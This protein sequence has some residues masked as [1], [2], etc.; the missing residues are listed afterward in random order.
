M[1]VCLM[2]FRCQVLCTIH[3]SKLL[4]F[5]RYLFQYPL[6]LSIELVHWF[7]K[8]QVV[9]NMSQVG[10][11]RIQIV[12]DRLCFNMKVSRNTIDHEKARYLAARMFRTMLLIELT[13]V[14]TSLFIDILCFGLPLF[15]F[16]IHFEFSFGESHE[17]LDRSIHFVVGTYRL[18]VMVPSKSGKGHDFLLST[19]VSLIHTIDTSHT[20]GHFV[21]IDFLCKLFPRGSKT[22][23]P[24]TPRSK[25]VNKGHFIVC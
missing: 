22:L 9:D 13:L 1:M 2:V 23:T 6:G 10:H 11:G 4:M 16:F 25:H 17:R 15:K 7:S 12:I 8:A 14:F 20:N 19:Q 3:G 24:N 18:L 5:L 21:G